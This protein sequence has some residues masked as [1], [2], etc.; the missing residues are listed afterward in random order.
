M[1]DEKAL[2]KKLGE[3]YINAF[4]RQIYYQRKHNNEMSFY[5]DG[6]ME[7]LTNI[8]SFIGERNDDKH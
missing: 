8:R 7:A 4:E 6:Y 1:I 3:S 5:Y 2:I